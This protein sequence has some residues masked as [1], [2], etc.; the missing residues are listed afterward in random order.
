MCKKN[1]KMLEK[2][3]KALN[4]KTACRNYRNDF[5]KAYKILYN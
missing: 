4:I 2:L 1:L 5:S 3:I